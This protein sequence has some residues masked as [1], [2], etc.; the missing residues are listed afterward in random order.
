MAHRPSWFR[1]GSVFV[2]Y[3][4]TVGINKDGNLLFEVDPKT[5][6]RTTT[7]DDKVSSDVDAVISGTSARTGRWID[8]DEFGVAVPAYYDLQHNAAL[9]EL[10]HTKFSGL[11]SRTLGDLIDAGELVARP[12]HGSPSADMRDGTFPYIKVS[13][14]RAGQININPTNR[15]SRV[16]AERFWR[17]ETSGLRPFD[18]VTP[19]RASKNIGEFAM[20][21]PGQEAVVFTKEVLI[22]RPGPNSNADSFFL[23]W[24]LSLKAV[25]DQW[26]RIVFMQTNREDVGKRYLEIAIPWP[27]SVVVGRELSRPFRAYYEGMEALRQSFMTALERDG[28]HYVFLGNAAQEHDVRE[29]SVPGRLRSSS[30]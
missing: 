12:G 1:D 14:I 22:L 23:M 26:K 18:L 28:E 20:L 5:G 29:A 21:M 27:D 15:V 6:K 30:S 16:V 3:A 9:D 2:S 4:D 19:V 10:I 17:G 13:D 11:K 8:A 25:R 7:I 24:A